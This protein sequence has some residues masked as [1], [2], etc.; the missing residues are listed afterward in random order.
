MAVTQVPK[1]KTLS[2][3]IQTEIDKAGDAIYSKKSFSG[4]KIAA[5]DQSVL[6]IAEAI[7]LVLEPNT[8]GTFINQTNTLV[9]A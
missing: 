8:R 3:E 5:T 2:I 1:S 9:N 6:D 4:V 7:K